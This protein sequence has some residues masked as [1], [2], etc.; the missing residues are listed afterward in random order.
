MQKMFIKCKECGVT[1]FYRVLMKNLF[2]CPDC[3]FH[4]PLH[5]YTRI[6]MLVDKG[7]FKEL[8]KKMTSVD[9]LNF[10]HYK[11][12]TKSDIKNT[13]LNSAVVSGTAKIDKFP[14]SMSV[15]DTRFRM[16]SMGSVVGEKITRSI[17]VSIEKSIPLIIICGSGGARMQEGLFSLMQM[18][19]TSA[20]LKKLA[21]KGGLYISV[22]THPTTAGVSASFA[23]L[24]DLIIAE[25]NAL[26]G[27]TG[28]RVIEQ[29]IGE[30]LPE[31]FQKS[32]FLLQ[33]GMLDKIV[34]RKNMKQTLSTLIKM[35]AGVYQNNINQ[36]YR[37]EHYGLE[38]K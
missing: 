9:P 11:D 32:E 29:T 8:D 26:I 25:P 34:H 13:K 20:A 4:H 19:K 22:L 1:H 27:F 23:F 21:N 14:V 36:K 15:M 18:A 6:K 7:S 30:K 33:H 24:G 3:D 28:P 5:A 12:K 17:E 37:I 31:G 38:R 16:A 10:P 2:I 35:H